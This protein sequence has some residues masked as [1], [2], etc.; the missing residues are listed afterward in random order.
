MQ[1]RTI[2]ARRSRNPRREPTTMPAIA[3]PESPLLLVSFPDEPPAVGDAVDVTVV[4]T[5]GIDVLL[6]VGRT[7]PS[8]RDSAF[9]PTQQESVALGELASQ[10]RQSPCKLLLKPQSFGSLRSPG[11]HSTLSE[12]AG[13]AQLVKSALIWSRKFELGFVQ[14]SVFIAICSSLVANRAWS[15]SV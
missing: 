3:P 2:K 1:Q 12:S 14:S 15:Q 6:K 4:V 5:G 11:I 9:D 10:K 8:Q 7:T 13:R